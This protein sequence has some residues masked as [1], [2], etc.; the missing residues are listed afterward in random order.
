MWSYSLN[1]SRTLESDWWLRD[2]ASLLVQGADV[3]RGL[4][5]GSTTKTTSFAHSS[6]CKTVFITEHVAEQKAAGMYICQTSPTCKDRREIHNIQHK[7][8]TRAL[9]HMIERWMWHSAG[10]IPGLN[11]LGR[12]LLSEC[13]RCPTKLWSVPGS[14]MIKCPLT[15]NMCLV[16]G[17]HED[18]TRGT[19]STCLLHC[20]IFLLR[21]R[22]LRVKRC[23]AHAAFVASAHSS[24]MTTDTTIVAT[25]FERK[26][27]R[28]RELQ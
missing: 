13:R 18:C 21:K 27:D 25:A 8:N 3:A 22:L 15:Q 6:K 24:T 12:A 28:D 10:I 11:L 5:G 19:H 14:M 2:L 16:R 4:P 1:G 9:V 23:R 20:C 17:I 7:H 26:G